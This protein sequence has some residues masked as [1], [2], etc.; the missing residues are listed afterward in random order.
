MI[1]SILSVANPVS[2]SH[3]FVETTSQLASVLDCRLDLAAVVHYAEFGIGLFHPTEEVQ[4]SRSR[5][6]DQCRAS[7][8]HSIADAQRPPRRIEARWD[9]PFDQGV[10]YQIDQLEPDL[11]AIALRGEHLSS[12]EWRLVQRCPVPLLIC[13]PRPLSGKARVLA[14]VDPTHEHDKPAAL[15]RLILRTAADIVQGFDGELEVLHAAGMLPDLSGSDPYPDDYRRTVETER[16]AIIRGLIPPSVLDTA[17]LKFSHTTAPE[18]ITAFA[19]AHSVDFCVMGSVA[20]SWLE[21]R[22]IGSTVR[23]VLPGL[24]C[25]VLLVPMAHSA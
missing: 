25:H 3:R 12:A 4:R 20:R 13:G 11:V 18:A 17:S 10:L 21:Q 9:H 22:F 24:G 19:N 6:V 23:Q 8:E 5:F 16:G 1:R 2:P 15:D 14:C 7:L